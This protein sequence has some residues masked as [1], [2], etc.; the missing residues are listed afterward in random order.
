MYNRLISLRKNPSRSFFLWGP[1]QTGKST[2]LRSL[3]PDAYTIDL[4]KSE[5]FAFYIQKPSRIRDLV[6]PS[7]LTV[8]D[9]VQKIPELLDEIQWCI[10]NQNRVFALCGSSA[11]KLRRNHANLLGGRALRFELQGLSA[12]ELGNGFN[13]TRLLNRGYLPSHYDCAEEDWKLLML[14]YVGDYLREEIAAE[15]LVRSL[16]IFSDFLSM[17]ALSDAETVN[18]ST[19]AR[20]IGVSSHTAKEYFNLLSDTL[21]GWFL[22]PYRHR[23]KRKAEAS[24]KFYFSDVAIVNFLAKRGTMEPGSELFGKAFENWV[25]HELR[26][27]N[28]Y[29][30]KFSDLSYWRSASGNDEVDFI[31]GD[32]QCAI[33]AKGVSRLRAEHFRGL[34]VLAKEHPEAG[35]RILVT[36]EGPQMRRADNV[37]VLNHQ[38]FVAS[39][40][41]GQLF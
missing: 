2:L 26:C 21:L 34:E 37:R 32:F 28:S 16:P 36:Y 14:S 1:R 7:P 18:F 4:L 29:R 3:Y 24:A 6:T 15:G 20:D 41:S 10:E 38:D 11:R 30:E 35:Q 19:M 13:L 39:L 25:G 17:A 31:V 40:W 8:V 33:E 5:V 12:A 23:P 27:Y 22:R 9:E